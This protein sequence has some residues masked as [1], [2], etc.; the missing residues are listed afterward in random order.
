MNKSKIDKIVQKTE[1]FS[2]RNYNRMPIA[3]ESARGAW[4]LD[5]DYRSNLEMLSCYSA[6]NF[7]HLHPRIVGALRRQLNKVAVIPQLYYNSTVADFYEKV[8]DFC[9]MDSVLAKNGGAEAIEAAIKLSRKWG[10]KIKRVPDG[11]AEIIC[12]NGN[13]HGRTYGPL[14]LS[15]VEQY[16]DGFGP[17]LSGFIKIPF[18]DLDALENVITENTVSFIVEPIQGEGGIIVPSDGYLAKSRE[19]CRRYNVLF[20]LDEIQTGFGRTGY[21][22]AYK[23]EGESAKPDIL[24]LGKALGGG[25]LPVSA[26]VTRREIM[27]VITPGD[28][29]ST[30]GGNPLA[31]A[32]GIEAINVL[33]EE[34]LSERARVLGGYLISELKKIESPCIKEVRGRGLLVGIELTQESIDARR[35]CELL[36]ERGILCKDAHEKVIRISPPLVIGKAELNSGICAIKKVFKEIEKNGQKSKK[37]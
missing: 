26:V 6:L 5:E 34:K 10:Y 14:S 28:D 9:D 24:I 2:A 36:L 4:V 7:G 13:F 12:C 27:S 31:C 22:L 19:I 35:F 15:D 11:M 37:T 16:R 25:L 23:Y 1:R 17:F 21:D 33:K 18:N 8:A 20:V 3:I 32:V 29:G 30:F